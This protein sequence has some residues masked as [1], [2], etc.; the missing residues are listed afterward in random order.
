MFQ[1]GVHVRVS[2]VRARVS[3]QGCP[4][5]GVRVRR[6]SLVSACVWPRCTCVCVTVCASVTDCERA[7][8]V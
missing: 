3:A 8:C 5:K 4:R 6:L 2:A 1:A 7:V